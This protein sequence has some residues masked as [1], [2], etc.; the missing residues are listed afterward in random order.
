MKDW[1]IITKS[2]NFVLEAFQLK[3][4]KR[5][6]DFNKDDSQIFIGSL[7]GII[8]AL[9]IIIKAEDIQLYHKLIDSLEKVA[10]K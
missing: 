10:W 5:V 9:A 6:D 4:V 1:N 8:Q 3:N 2:S 7:A